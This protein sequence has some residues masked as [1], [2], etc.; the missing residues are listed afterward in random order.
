MNKY[1]GA[2]KLVLRHLHHHDVADCP[3]QLKHIRALSI[4][5][6]PILIFAVMLQIKQTAPLI[7]A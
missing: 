7:C 5:Y 2:L 6:Q 4:T 1:T 3:T